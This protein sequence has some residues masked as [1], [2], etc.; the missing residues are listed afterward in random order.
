ML[1]SLFI[2]YSQIGY[3]VLGFDIDQL[4]VDDLNKGHSAIEH[5]R[6]DWVRGECQA[7]KPQRI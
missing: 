2:R 5:I 1:A 7:L 4:K 6:D 3:S